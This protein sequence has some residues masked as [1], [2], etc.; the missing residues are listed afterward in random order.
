[1][2]IKR[3]YQHCVLHYSDCT[4]INLQEIKAQINDAIIITIIDVRIIIISPFLF[5]SVFLPLFVFVYKKRD[6]EKHRKRVC[7]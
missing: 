2:Q 6:C 3:S 5:F 4:R 7:V 1:M